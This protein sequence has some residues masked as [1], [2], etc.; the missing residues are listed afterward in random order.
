MNLPFLI[1]IKKDSK[2]QKLD[3]FAFS[4]TQIKSIF[5]PSYTK[6]IDKYTFS[7]CKKLQKVSFA[8][9]SEL[10]IIDKRA[11]LN[12]SSLTKI[13]L[14]SQINQIC[15]SAF[16]RNSLL[17]T[18]EFKEN[19]QLKII[20]SN[21]FARTAIQL[22]SLPIHVI[23]IGKG[24]FNCQKL[25]LFEIVDNSELREIS[26]NVFNEKKLDCLIIPAELRSKLII[27]KD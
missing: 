27:K 5:I 18:I 2:L 20:E 8:V 10:K 17:K 14:P 1:E 16:A 4:E 7:Y 24:A 23:Q 12:C 3:E 19:C 6:I 11:F 21:A 13:T 22:F 15:D 25:V 9:D 26:H